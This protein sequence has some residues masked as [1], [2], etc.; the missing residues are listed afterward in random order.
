MVPSPV[1]LLVVLTANDSEAVR[2]TA[3][4]PSGGCCCEF[5]PE[6][7]LGGLKTF[8]NHVFERMQ[9]GASKVAAL[10]AV[11]AAVYYY[12]QSS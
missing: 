10:R 5:E 1:K 8:V 11:A 6:A 12:W 7:F 3:P 4:A 2:P 9:A